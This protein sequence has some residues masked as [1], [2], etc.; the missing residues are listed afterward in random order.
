MELYLHHA[1]LSDPDVHTHGVVA[2][3]KPVA[4]GVDVALS[5]LDRLGASIVQLDT[6]YLE[7]VGVVEFHGMGVEL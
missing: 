2:A 7:M 5:D 3:V 4:S 6:V 1:S